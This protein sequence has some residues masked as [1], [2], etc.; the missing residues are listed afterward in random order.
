MRIGQLLVAAVFF[1]SLPAIADDQYLRGN[2]THKLRMMDCSAIASRVRLALIC[3]AMDLKGK[4]RKELIDLSNS[5]GDITGKF[6]GYGA[7]EFKNMTA[8]AAMRAAITE[9]DSFLA[10][11]RR[12]MFRNPKFDANMRKIRGYC[13]YFV[14]S[15]DLFSNE[16]L[17][18]ALTHKGC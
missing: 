2:G 15:R 8:P 16:N 7:T 10:E 1:V 18:L 4:E 6:R 13:G 14:P 12:F 9:A 5:Y 3:E 17:R 11:V